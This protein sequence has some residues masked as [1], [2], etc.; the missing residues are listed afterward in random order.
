MLVVDTA[1]L[2]PPITVAPPEATSDGQPKKLLA[3][4]SFLLPGANYLGWVPLRKDRG[5]GS[6]G[7]GFELSF[8]HHLD[9]PSFVV[10]A[11][12][13]VERLDRWRLGAGVEAG[14]ELIGVEL[15]CVRELAERD[16]TRAQW[17]MQIAPYVSFG[18]VNIAARWVIALSQRSAVDAPG[19]GAMIVVGFKVPIRLTPRPE[20]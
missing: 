20:P 8:A 11:L 19:D 15:S 14:Y 17:S 6:A 16:S 10:G 3:R 2:T 5:I 9:D 13:Q 7:Y 12:G 4:S 1:L 18:F